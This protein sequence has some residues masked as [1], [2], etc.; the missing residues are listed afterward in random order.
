MKKTFNREY[1]D[2]PK[3]EGGGHLGIERNEF[4]KAPNP[5]KH[6]PPGTSTGTGWIEKN[7][8]SPENRNDDNSQPS[9]LSYPVE[10]EKTYRKGRRK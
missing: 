6:E 4:Q 9:R 3:T 5:I 8:K 10:N 2:N 7:Y 1:V